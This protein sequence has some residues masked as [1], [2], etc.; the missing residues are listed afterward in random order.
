MFSKLLSLKSTKV[1]ASLKV[2]ES[3][4]E[5]PTLE[6]ILEYFDPEAAEKYHKIRLK[7]CY[8]N[9]LSTVVI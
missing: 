7:A 6:T 1:E 2:G 4:E 5:K 9:L 3:V 8:A